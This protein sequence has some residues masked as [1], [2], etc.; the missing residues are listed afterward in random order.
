MISFLLEHAYGLCLLV[1]GL[2]KVFVYPSRL[3]ALVLR[4]SSHRKSFAAERVGQQTLQRLDFVPSALLCCLDD[5]RLE[6]THILV[7]GRPVNGSPVH[8]T[9]GSRTSKRVRCHLPCLLDLFAKFSRHERPN[10]SRLTFVRD[11]VVGNAIPLR[12]ITERHSLFPFSFAR[13]LIGRP[14]G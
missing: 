2:P 1:W 14:C 12:S 11:D 6:P 13:N 5:T 4:H 7:D 9:V 3:L 8:L 10:G